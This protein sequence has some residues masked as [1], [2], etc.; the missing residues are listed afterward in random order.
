MEGKRLALFSLPGAAEPRCPRQG[1]KEGTI[2]LLRPSV[3]F[4]PLN[5]LVTL[6]TPDCPSHAPLL[7]AQGSTC[8]SQLSSKKVRP[9]STTQQPL[10]SFL[11]EQSSCTD[12][13]QQLLALPQ[14]PHTSLA[15]QLPALRAQCP[16]SNPCSATGTDHGFCSLL[17]LPHSPATSTLSH[18]G[19]TALSP[20]LQAAGASPISWAGACGVTLRCPFFS[21]SLWDV[22]TSPRV[23]ALR[24]HWALGL[25]LSTTSQ[26][27]VATKAG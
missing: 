4:S 8:G 6:Q 19:H 9:Y 11:S 14:A 26:R 18:W 17:Q 13:P 22:G 3:V 12:Q 16:D 21:L 25:S 10:T 7:P 20:P 5:A 1:G 15:W 24:P 27:L 23:A 2:S